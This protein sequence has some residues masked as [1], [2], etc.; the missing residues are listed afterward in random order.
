MTFNLRHHLEA[1]EESNVDW[2]CLIGGSS[3][4]GPHRVYRTRQHL[5]AILENSLSLRP[6]QDLL[7]T[8]LWPSTCCD[9]ID[10]CMACLRLIENIR[11]SKNFGLKDHFTL[12]HVSLLLK[13]ITQ[14]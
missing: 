5:K 7:R 12:Q 11:G 13:V 1:L 10:Q 9:N 14:K 2:V 4:K 6:R 8:L 3:D